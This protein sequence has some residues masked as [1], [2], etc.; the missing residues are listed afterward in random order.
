M[1]GLG[2][3]V[4]PEEPQPQDEGE[5]TVG[6]GEPATPEEQALYKQVV[7]NAVEVIYPK[8]D[9]ML[10]PKLIEALQAGENPVMNLALA[11][12]S[13]VRGLKESARA[14]GQ[15]IPDEILYYAGS[16]VIEVIAEAA[17]A[18]KIAEYSEE[19]LERALFIAADI[20]REQAAAAGEI[21]EDEAK[22]EFA[23]LQQA[24]A[25]GRLDDYLPGAAKRA[26]QMPQQP[27]EG[28]GEGMA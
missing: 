8:G 22:A 25:E 28:A 3:A 16:E 2:A 13:V 11:A 21:D 26:A 6:F 9:D 10:A 12:V 17:E 24:D 20:Y 1:A 19:D 5:E 7:E 15:D 18:A 4:R 27:P 14:A 23:E